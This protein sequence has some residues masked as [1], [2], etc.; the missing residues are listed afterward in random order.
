MEFT[1][2]GFSCTK[3]FGSSLLPSL[4]VSMV[5][6]SPTDYLIQVFLD[7]AKLS[8]GHHGCM[9]PSCTVKWEFTNA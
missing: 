6:V 2:Q 5:I 9:Q 1:G 8:H 4:V 7:N 3:S